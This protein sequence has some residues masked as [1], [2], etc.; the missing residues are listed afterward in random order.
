MAEFKASRDWDSGCAFPARANNRLSRTKQQRLRR[1]NHSDEQREALNRSQRDRYVNQSDEQRE[2]LNRNQNERRHHQ[3]VGLIEHLYPVDI[4]S[5][6]SNF[7]DL[8]GNDAINF[9]ENL[10]IPHPIANRPRGYSQRP[11]PFT[12][13]QVLT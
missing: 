4:S 13:Q 1:A 12:Q 7:S 10:F 6:L 5:G 2:A 9:V 11:T 3:A 8:S